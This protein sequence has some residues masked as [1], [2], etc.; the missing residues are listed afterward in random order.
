MEI[1]KSLSS[2][3]RILIS[4]SRLD[5]ILRLNASTHS[6]YK[7]SIWTP[8]TQWKNQRSGSGRRCRRTER[9]WLLMRITI[10]ISGALT[11]KRYDQRH[12]NCE[13]HKRR[14]RVLG[15]VRLKQTHVHKPN[16]WTR[17]HLCPPNRWRFSVF[18]AIRADE[19]A[20]WCIVTRADKRHI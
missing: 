1:S 3:R 7:H 4:K 10:I 2:K 12:N 19:S 6:I 14:V 17:H 8:L 15:S 20:V 9:Q 13:S 16:K 18:W 11:R 5:S